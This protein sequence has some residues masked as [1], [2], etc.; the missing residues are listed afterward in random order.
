MYNDSKEY[1]KD[2]K[3][4]IDF[5]LKNNMTENEIRDIFLYYLAETLSSEKYRKITENK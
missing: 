4:A 5:M 2:L 1:E 3:E